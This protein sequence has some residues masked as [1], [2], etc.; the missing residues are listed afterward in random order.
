MLDEDHKLVNRCPRRGSVQG[1]QVNPG[2]TTIEGVLEA[3]IHHAG[4]ISKDN[5]GD[6][7][8]VETLFLLKPYGTV[9]C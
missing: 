8:K 9:R 6:I 4:G 2:V 5:F 1:M 3:A 7:N